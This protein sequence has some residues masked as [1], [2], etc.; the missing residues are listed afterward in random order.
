MPAS[1]PSQGSKLFEGRT[2]SLL[3]SVN[4]MALSMVSCTQY[5]PNACEHREAVLEQSQAVCCSQQ[6]YKGVVSGASHKWS[7]GQ[8]GHCS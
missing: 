3:T 7:G 4:S 6:D 1:S 5:M 2:Y 8:K